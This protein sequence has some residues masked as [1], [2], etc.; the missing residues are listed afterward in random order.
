MA[1]VERE[2]VSGTGGSEELCAKR[3]DRH[4][5]H[6]QSEELAK[7]VGC[8]ATELFEG[9]DRPEC[10]MKTNLNALNGETMWN[11]AVLRSD[12]RMWGRFVSNHGVPSSPTSAPTSP[13][14]PSEESDSGGSY[15]MSVGQ[16]LNFCIYQNV[17][18]RSL[19]CRGSIPPHG[20]FRDICIWND[21]TF[22]C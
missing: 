7:R 17:Y 4:G 10:F 3:M 6:C 11:S 19:P 2:S 16:G 12:R 21:R 15:I 8:S 18:A 20:A 1:P 22:A 5:S 9:F 14:T 13:R